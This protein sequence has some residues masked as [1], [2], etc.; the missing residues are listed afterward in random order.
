MPRGIKILDIADLADG[1]LEVSYT[2]GALPLPVGQSGAL[3]FLS[4]KQI[5]EEIVALESSM[6]DYQLLLLLMAI[7]WLKVDGTFRNRAQV[8]GA[9]LDMDLYAVNVLK[10]V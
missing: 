7:K 4:K 6:T 10:V 5:E 1:R 8:I 9:E 2:S 3:T